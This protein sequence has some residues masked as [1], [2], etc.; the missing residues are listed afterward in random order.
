MT[1]KGKM[2]LLVAAGIGYYLYSRGSNRIAGYTDASGNPI[3]TAVCGSTI[4]FNVPG[5]N[6]IW[7]EVRQNGNLT[8]DGPFNV[9]MRAYP[10]NC[11]TDIG[12][13]EATYYE[14]VAGNKGSLIGRATLNVTSV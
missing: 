9:P 3:A 4:G 6:Q 2:G 1:E 5:Y 7:L 13:F 14:S 10:L 12:Q 11:M 8:F